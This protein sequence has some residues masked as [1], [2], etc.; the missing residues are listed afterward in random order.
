MNRPGEGDDRDR[1]GPVRPRLDAVR[2][3][4]PFPGP[5]AESAAGVLDLPAVDAG[6]AYVGDQPD[7]AGSR[8]RL[9]DAGVQVRVIGTD[10]GLKSLVCLRP[11]RRSRLTPQ[12]LRFRHSQG[13][14]LRIEEERCE[15]RSTLTAQLASVRPTA[16]LERALTS[17]GSATAVLSRTQLDFLLDCADA[18][19]DPDTFRLFGPIRCRRWPSVRWHDLDLAVSWQVLPQD[20][21]PALQVLEISLR[22]EPAAAQ[23]RQHALAVLL[24]RHGLHPEDLPPVTT[25]ALLEHLTGRLPGV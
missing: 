15:E 19:I 1:A 14:E 12:W 23:I 4:V 9:L 24:H 17:A 22:V 18:R 6:L 8:F 7:T 25:Q 20:P 16:T 11:C 5:A 3:V 2:I 21:R 13:D 10:R